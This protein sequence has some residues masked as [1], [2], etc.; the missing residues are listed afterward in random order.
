MSVHNYML[1][2]RAQ[3][4]T[5]TFGGLN[6]YS[7]SGLYKICWNLNKHFIQE[8]LLVV[9]TFSI[10]FLFKFQHILFR[11]LFEYSSYLSL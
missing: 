6:K 5:T 9:K 3:N 7:K 1:V 2:N 11:L 10:K 4:V 8:V